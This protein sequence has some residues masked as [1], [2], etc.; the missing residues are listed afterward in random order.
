[1]YLSVFDL[2]DVKRQLAFQ[3]R[4]WLDGVEVTTDCQIAIVNEPDQADG[5]R[6]LKRDADG[7]HYVEPNGDLAVEWKHGR[8]TIQLPNASAVV[9]GDG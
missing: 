8:I 3:S 4:V 2:D 9:S 1:M 7:R 5:V 6:L